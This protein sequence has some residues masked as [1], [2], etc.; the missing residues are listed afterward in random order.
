MIYLGKDPIGVNKFNNNEPHNYAFDGLDLS[1]VFVDADALQAALANEDY[2]N[3]HIG[4]Y[5]PVTLNGTYRDYGNMTVPA[6]TTYYSDEEMTTAAG[7]TSD[8][9]IPTLNGDANYIGSHKPFNTIKI[10][11]VNYYVPWNSCLEY[12]ERTLSNAIMKFEVAGINQYWRYGDSGT[13]TGN[14][15]HLLLS[16]RDGLPHTL[17]QRKCN[18]TWENQRIETFEGDGSTSV[19]TVSQAKIGTMGYVFVDGVKKTYNTDYTF[20]RRN[21]KVTFK[22][23]KIPAA[24]TTVTIEYID[25]TN[26]W[27]GSALYRTFNDPNYGIIKLIQTADP[28]LYSHIYTGPNGAGMRFAGE[29]RSKTNQQEV[30]WTDRGILFLPT[31]DEVWGRLLYSTGYAAWANQQQWPIYQLGGRR[32]FAK[33]AGNGASRTNIW[34]S[35]ST[36]VT[37]FAVVYSNANPNNNNAANGNVAAPCFLIA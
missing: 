20:D 23:G 28:K 19:F 29:N 16:A 10:S 26:P 12:Q 11:N 27:T 15:P 13:I 35:S 14:K 25:A 34:T 22:T 37:T 18:E 8:I 4:D 5:W 33:G 32:H 24:G 2:E 36:S 17:K 21:G 30:G 9:I 3:I 1:K 6:G 7:T 31:E